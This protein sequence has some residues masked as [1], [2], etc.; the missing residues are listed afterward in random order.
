MTKSMKTFM[1]AL[2]AIVLSSCGAIH[3]Q[4]RMADT[5]NLSAV[6]LG[7]TKAEVQTALNKKPDN[8]VSSSQDPIKHATVEVVQYSQ[9]TS[10]HD[11]TNLRKLNSYW[12]Y[13]VNDKL[14]SWEEIKPDRRPAS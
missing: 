1:V 7:M 5:V 10:N 6:K 2:L 3:E 8:I 4:M 13:F 14:D 12:L 9:W 11:N